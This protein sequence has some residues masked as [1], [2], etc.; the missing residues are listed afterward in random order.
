MVTSILGRLA[1]IHNRV[2]NM[3]MLHRYIFI[4]SR[5]PR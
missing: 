2:G 3:A 5:N 1:W 4:Q